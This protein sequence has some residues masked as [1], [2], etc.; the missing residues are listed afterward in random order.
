MALHAPAQR[1]AIAQLGAWQV[2]RYDRS[3]ERYRYFVTRGMLHLQLWNSA[4]RISVLTPSMLTG[5]RFEIWRDGMRIAVRTWA[6]VAE[7]LADE[8]PPNGAE[9]AALQVWLVVRDE[10]DARRGAAAARRTSGLGPRDTPTTVVN[11]P[12]PSS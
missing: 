1:V 6:E 4:A 3:G 12:S 10:V 9:L 7:H 2:R 11:D 5:G 8:A